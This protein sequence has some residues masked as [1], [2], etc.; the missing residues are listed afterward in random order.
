MTTVSR[1]MSDERP[2]DGGPPPRERTSPRQ[3][4]KEVR[5]ELRR[6][7]WPSRREVASYSV[8][9]LVVVSLLGLFLVGLDQAFSRLVFFLF[10]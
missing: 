4:L 9:V 10:G 3:F 5:G 1:T 2:A 7:A 6:V 8:V